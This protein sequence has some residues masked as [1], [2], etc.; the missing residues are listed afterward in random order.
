[1]FTATLWVLGPSDINWRINALF[2]RPSRRAAID[3]A[4]TELAWYQERGYR[5]YVRVEAPELPVPLRS[6]EVG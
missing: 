2:H 3:R 6:G 1:M 5:G 4:S